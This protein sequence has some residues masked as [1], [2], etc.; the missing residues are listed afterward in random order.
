MNKK[1]QMVELVFTD[2]CHTLLQPGDQGTIEYVDDI[3]TVFVKWEN[4]SRLGL[5]PELDKWIQIEDKVAGQ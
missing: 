5:I 1:G 2:D 4:G 3:G